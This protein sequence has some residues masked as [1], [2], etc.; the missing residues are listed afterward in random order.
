[1]ESIWNQIKKTSTTFLQPWFNTWARVKILSR[2]VDITHRLFAMTL[3]LVLETTL[4]C[5]VSELTWA[6]H[7]SLWH[8]MMCDEIY[9]C[10]YFVSVAVMA[11]WSVLLPHS[12]VSQG[13]WDWVGSAKNWTLFTCVKDVKFVR[14]MWM[15]Q[16]INQ[17][18]FSCELKV[19]KKQAWLG[20]CK[21]NTH[22]LMTSTK[23]YFK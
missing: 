15:D 1:M 7:V 19:L 2:Q 10:K 4:K 14:D 11:V 22:M 21:T 16:Y 18:K 23:K 20:I 13:S 12:L 17:I 6:C 8:A 3:L 9:S 5:K